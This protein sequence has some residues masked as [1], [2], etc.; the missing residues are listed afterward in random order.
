MY[1]GEEEEDYDKEMGKL[2]KE[3]QEQI[4]W[5]MWAPEQDQQQEEVR[6]EHYLI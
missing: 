3:N 1:A 6:N 2:G 4:D 5:N